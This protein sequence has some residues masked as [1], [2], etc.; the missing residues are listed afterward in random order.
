MRQKI[1]FSKPR[2]IPRPDGLLHTGDF[3]IRQEREMVRAFSSG[4][5]TIVLQAEADKD[6][7][8][9]V[10]NVCD[11]PNGVFRPVVVRQKRKFIREFR[12]DRSFDKTKERFRLRGHVD[13]S[14]PY[15]C[16]VADGH[17]AFPLERIVHERHEMSRECFQRCAVPGAILQHRRRYGKHDPLGREA[18]SGENVVDQEAVNPPVSVLERVQKDESPGDDRGMDHGGPASIATDRS[19]RLLRP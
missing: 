3:I 14:I 5:S 18:A 17:A 4:E 2:R 6:V 8:F 16:I 1:S 19:L 12:I 9:S 11:L 15:G 13:I 10:G 7:D